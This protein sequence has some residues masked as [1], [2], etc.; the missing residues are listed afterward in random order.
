MACA[1][2][3]IRGIFPSDRRKPFRRTCPQLRPNPPHSPPGH[4]GNDNAHDTASG[5]MSASC[6]RFHGAPVA[7]V[8]EWA[9][10]GG[11]GDDLTALIL[12]AR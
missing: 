4:G 6:G 9:G 7:A 11:L 10:A 12:K 3:R 8:D 1:W 5:L 2:V